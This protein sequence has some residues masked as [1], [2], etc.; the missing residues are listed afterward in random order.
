MGSDGPGRPWT[1]PFQFREEL[2]CECGGTLERLWRL[3]WG[4]LSGWLVREICTGEHNVWPATLVGR[5]LK[6]RNFSSR[7]LFQACQGATWS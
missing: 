7:S 5:L 6:D 4:P 3:V 2:P 1:A